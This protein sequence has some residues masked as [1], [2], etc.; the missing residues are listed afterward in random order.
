MNMTRNRVQ[1]AVRVAGAQ[2]AGFVS[3]SLRRRVFLKLSSLTK[4]VYA[5]AATYI[6]WSISGKVIDLE[7]KFPRN[8]VKMKE[9]MAGFFVR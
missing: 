7:A 3:L 5:C 2:F 6:T 8:I 9:E 4:K 1:S